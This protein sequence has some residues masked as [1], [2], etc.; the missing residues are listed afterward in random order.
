M[1]KFL[2]IILTTLIACQKEKS[3][4]IHYGIETN[5]LISLEGENGG[6]LLDNNIEF[7]KIKLESFG[8]EGEKTLPFDITLETIS[9]EAFVVHPPKSK[10]ELNSLELYLLYMHPTSTT[11]I[12][13]NN[14]LDAD[15]L[16]GK[17]SYDKKR[18]LFKINKL[19]LNGNLVTSFENNKERSIVIKK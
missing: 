17:I 16:T 11:V 3:G 10:N 15:T 1:K 4:N 2:F 12:N 7:E 18:D 5:V 19:F 8:K 9:P 13:W 6:D 14:G